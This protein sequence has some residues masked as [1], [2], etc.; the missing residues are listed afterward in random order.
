MRR[1]REVGKLQ[2]EEGR[3]KEERERERRG[4]R[5]RRKEGRSKTTIGTE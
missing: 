1:G 2:A 3:K 5:R 4:V